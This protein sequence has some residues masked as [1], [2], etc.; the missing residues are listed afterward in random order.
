MREKSGTSQYIDLTGLQRAST[1]FGVCGR[2]TRIDFDSLFSVI[3]LFCIKRRFKRAHD[4]RFC[5][6]G[7]KYDTH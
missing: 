3:I 4:Y 1:G 7:C 5:F 6:T 2:S